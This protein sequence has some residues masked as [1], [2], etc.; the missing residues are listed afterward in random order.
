MKFQLGAQL[1]ALRSVIND[2]RS[3]AATLQVLARNNFSF[4]EPAGFNLAAQTFQGIDFKLLEQ[5]AKKYGLT[6]P[7]VHVEINTKNARAIADCFANSNLR[8]IVLP[9][10]NVTGR[11]VEE[12]LFF[13]EELNRIASI[14]KPYNLKL[15]F[16]NHIAELINDSGFIP[17][18]ILLENTTDNIVFEMDL[19]WINAAG[20]SPT[21]Y[22][23]KY[24]GR[25]ALWHLRDIDKNHQTVTP[26]EGEVNFAA[27]LSHP[28][29]SGLEFAVIELASGMPD[30][31]EKMITG[32]NNI[33]NLLA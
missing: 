27:A 16:H 29:R 10:L 28:E 15:A 30:P 12:Y 1:W 26:G 7:C 14:L 25:F 11:Y 32:I 2:E 19:G 6:M 4:I 33:T 24:P 23:Q 18:D 31:V 20:L 9:K 8:Y 21:N 17:Y 22:F 13:S 3:L 5:E